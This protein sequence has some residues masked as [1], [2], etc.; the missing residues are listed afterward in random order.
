MV[1]D[2]ATQLLSDVLGSIWAARQDAL[3]LAQLLQ[4]A[5]GK[6]KKR[7]LLLF[8]S[9]L[10]ILMCLWNEHREPKHRAY[11][12]SKI[13]ICCTSTVLFVSHKGDTLLEN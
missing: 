8:S 6:G 7:P 10:E 1:T 13:K 4:T 11:E 5:S 2:S 12:V 3:V 9:V